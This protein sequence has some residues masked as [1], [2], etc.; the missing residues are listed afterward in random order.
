MLGRLR[1][2]AASMNGTGGPVS[3]TVEADEAYIGGKEKNKHASKRQHKGTGGVGKQ[4]VMAAVERGGK[5]RAKMIANA[6]RHEMQGFIRENVAAG[7]TLYTD[8]HPAFFGLDGYNHERV[9]HS[10][11]EYVRDKAHTNGI[12]SFWALLKR[13]YVGTFHNFS[14][15][16]LDRY[17][18][19]FSAR[20]NMMGL[21]EDARLDSILESVVGSRLTYKRLIA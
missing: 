16:H 8:E 1:E 12:E 4:I 5:V 13:G 3:G 20:W 14:W 10:V 15:K 2:V 7:C 18:S 19:E 21:R 6:N 17:L 9:N 11:G